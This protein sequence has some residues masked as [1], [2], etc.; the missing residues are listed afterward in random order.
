MVPMSDEESNLRKVLDPWYRKPL[1]VSSPMV[2]LDVGD[3]PSSK[4]HYGWDKKEQIPETSQDSIIP[5]P[6]LYTDPYIWTCVYGSVSD[7]NPLS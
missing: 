3:R 6:R 1:E 7:V 4:R 5:F 2:D